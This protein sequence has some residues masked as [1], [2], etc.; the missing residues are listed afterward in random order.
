MDRKLL[1]GS[2]PE[3]RGQA[4]QSDGIVAAFEGEQTGTRPY[5]N[6]RGQE[7][8]GT[9]RWLQD[10]QVLLMAEQDFLETARITYAILAV[11][12]SV[13][14]ASILIAIYIA[15]SVTHN[16]AVPV[17]DLSERASEIASGD[18]ASHGRTIAWIIE[19]SDELGT[20]AQAF[21]SMRYQLRAF[22]SGLEQRVAE[23]T[24]ELEVRTNYLE[25]SAQVSQAIASILDADR[26]I[27]QAVELIREN[28]DLYYV[29]IFLVDSIDDADSVRNAGSQR[30]AV[31]RSGTGE[32]GKAMLARG[33]R[34]AVDS[35]ASMI[36]WSIV[37]AQARI[38]QVAEADAIRL[39]TAELPDTRSEAAIPLRSRG[40]V[41]GAIS[42]QSDRPQAFDETSIS[43]LQTMADQLAVAIDNARLF[44]ESQYA[45]DAERRA[46]GDQSRAAWTE[47]ITTGQIQSVRGDN[48]GIHLTEPIWHPEMRQA[49]QSAR[50]VLQKQSDHNDPDGNDYDSTSVPEIGTDADVRTESSPLPSKETTP[51]RKHALAIPIKVRGNVIGV[52]DTYKWDRS[53]SGEEWT[54]E[55]VA[56][57]E[58]ITE[59]LGVALDSARLYMETQQ[60]AEQER[61]IGEVTSN[62]RQSLDVEAVLQTAVDEI[63]KALGL[64]NIVIQLSASQPESDGSGQ[65]HSSTSNGSNYDAHRLNSRY[66]G[67]LGDDNGR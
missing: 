6:F 58:N 36:G 4:V 44:T 8:L 53:K 51:R 65:F 56:F 39:A 30:W 3:E 15:L 9:Y 64:E 29:G 61:L 35:K 60:R 66:D 54:E 40:Q 63:Y 33:H 41:L 7:V 2:K 62:M 34:L 25:A 23:R 12:A 28:F 5:D 16:I 46:Y 45:L 32:A 26:L 21:D 19:R 49:L 13:G 52:L 31:L 59:Q 57:L 20:L 27:E 14:L 42:V 37:N 55:E 11:N 24:H 50:T 17:S 38:A 47:W 18:L 22:I 43:V 1:A 10:L 48:S 67:P